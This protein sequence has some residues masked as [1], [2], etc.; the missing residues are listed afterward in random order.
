MLQNQH[1]NCRNFVFFHNCTNPLRSAQF[2]VELVTIKSRR[3]LQVARNHA[4]EQGHAQSLYIIVVKTPSASGDAGAA[5][6]SK[7]SGRRAAPNFLRVSQLLVHHRPCG[8][9]AAINEFA[10]MKYIDAEVFA[11]LPRRGQ[12]ATQR[13]RG[14]HGANDTVK[15]ERR[16]FQ[17]QIDLN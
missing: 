14:S 9:E 3:L 16:H 13:N 7:A 4:T 8:L 10:A 15:L 11:T 2:C 5:T 17:S 12:R 1:F 6:V